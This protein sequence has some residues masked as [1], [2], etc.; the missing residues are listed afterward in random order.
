MASNNAI[1]TEL[2]GTIVAVDDA[3][4]QKECTNIIKVY[5]SNKIVELVLKWSLITTGFSVALL[6]SVWL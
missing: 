2:V 1:N 4:K 6:Y 5:F 3:W